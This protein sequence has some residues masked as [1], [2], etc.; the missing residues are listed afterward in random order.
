MWRPVQRLIVLIGVCLLL[1]SSVWA[2]D[3]SILN[4]VQLLDPTFTASVAWLSPLTSCSNPHPDIFAWICVD[5]T[6]NVFE[7]T[8][9]VDAAGREYGTGQYGSLPDSLGNTA[10]FKLQRLDAS[11]V[12]TD[13]ADLFVRRCRGGIPCTYQDYYTYAR[14][15]IVDI[16][17]GRILIGVTVVYQ[18][19]G[20]LQAG[21]VEI[22]GAPKL[23]DTLL[24]FVPGG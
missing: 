6:S 13:I 2:A 18:G 12:V 19:S 24:T 14:K 9:G 1:A 16:V 8:L 22:D 23:F 5:D 21:I 4:A 7:Q 11:G 15:P 17:N 3:L 20:D 10:G